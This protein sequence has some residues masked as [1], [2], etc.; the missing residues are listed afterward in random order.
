M[1]DCCPEK[2]GAGTATDIGS[3][4]RK[5]LPQGTAVARGRQQSW[6][7]EGQQTLG[8]GKLGIFAHRERDPD[9]DTGS[10]IGAVADHEISIV[11]ANPLADA[12]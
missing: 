3:L 8:R 5:L 4:A 7:D 12:E 2:G 1:S 11:L 6:V 10:S 9:L